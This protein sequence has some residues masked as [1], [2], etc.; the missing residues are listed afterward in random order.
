VGALNVGR[1]RV[2]GVP[3][4]PIAELGGGLELE[5]GAELARFEMGS[6][7]VLVSPPGGLVPLEETRLGESIKMGAR[8]ARWS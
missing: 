8:L 7:I 6:T 2:V 1:I 5:R 3:P 4:A